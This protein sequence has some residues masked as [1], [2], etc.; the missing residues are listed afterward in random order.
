MYLLFFFGTVFLIGIKIFKQNVSVSTGD[1]SASTFD[2]L[3]FSLSFYLLVSTDFEYD[4]E[5]ADVNE[6]VETL[7]FILLNYDSDKVFYSILNLNYVCR[8]SIIYE[9]QRAK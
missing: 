8:V 7:Y 6:D 5:K 3:S 2:P 9:K 1:L 4:S